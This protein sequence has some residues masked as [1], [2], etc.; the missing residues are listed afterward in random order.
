MSEPALNDAAKAVRRDADEASIRLHAGD[1]TWQTHLERAEQLAA[2]ITDE[3][4]AD[5]ALTRLSLVRGHVAS[6]MGDYPLELE[7][8][9][10]AMEAIARQK[11]RAPES[12]QARLVDHDWG[13]RFSRIEPLRFLGRLQEAVEQA[14]E[15]LEMAEATPEPG[16]RRAMALGAIAANS[17]EA[18]EVEQA[19]RD[20][21]R[22]IAEMRTHL[23]E[24]LGVTMMGLAQ[25]HFVA[26]RFDEA[27]LHLQRAEAFSV[28]DA[29]LQAQIA[30]VRAQ[31]AAHRQQG[32]AGGLLKEFAEQQGPGGRFG[33]IKE[34]ARQL[35]LSLDGDPAE[36]VE[37]ARQAALAQQGGP[38]EWSN[39]VQFANLAQDHAL[40]TGDAT[41]HQAA[42]EA[43]GRAVDLLEE[44]SLQAAYLI[45]HDAE[46][47]AQWNQDIGW[48]NFATLTLV[49]QQ[50]KEAL[51]KILEYQPD[52]VRAW[53]DDYFN[54][55]FVPALE[56]A[57]DL[58]FRLG[59]KD[60]LAEL[61]EAHA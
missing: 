18:R 30:Y 38:G 32:D 35:A 49:L 58:A 28:G 59:K 27:E 22:A 61:V 47:V 51:A 45:S 15:C 8:R 31:L 56:T 46:F 40:V 14:Q 10:V 17:L 4:S 21:E 26:H 12:G 44:N 3:F 36:A 41:Y 1:P 57:C 53:T 54:V 29:Y 13:A 33:A 11:A 60:E 20:Y 5:D 25:C 55:Y 2:T 7:H 50:A 48:H 6:W 37:Q 19:V 23:P 16:R 43:L 52:G 39:M 24:A 42:R 34:D 9:R